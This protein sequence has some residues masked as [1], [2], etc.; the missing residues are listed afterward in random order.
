MCGINEGATICCGIER[1]L[2]MAM[3]FKP[4]EATIIKQD[5]LAEFAREVRKAIPGP[6]YWE[7]C[8]AARNN[9]SQD[10][11]NKMK[12]MCKL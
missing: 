11:I 10:D 4:S 3:T 8:R 2:D 5:K 12:E 7:E 6:E 1:S 9:F